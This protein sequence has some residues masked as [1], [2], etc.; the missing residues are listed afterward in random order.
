MRSGK[1]R[2]LSNILATAAIAT[3]RPAALHNV[4]APIFANSRALRVHGL[5]PHH[6]VVNN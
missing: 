1:I 5:L 4:E 3:R 6:G 2:P